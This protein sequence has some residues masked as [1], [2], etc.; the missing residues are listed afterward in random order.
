[1]RWQE[2]VVIPEV[3]EVVTC[4]CCRRPTRSVEGRLTL[5]EEP[6]AR[7]NVRWQPGH[8]EH[9]ARHVLYLGDWTRKGGM[10]DGPAVAAADYQG[11][12]RHGFYL[13]DD[14]AQLLPALK[15][16]RPHY[17]RRADAIGKPL[18]ERLFAM[19]DAIH[20]KDSRLLELR[21]W[22]RAPGEAAG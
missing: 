21:E 1:M 5:H 17:I 10:Q 6:L 2:I 14:A 8:P 4:D 22:G 11:G 19:L 12:D 18:G 7:F 13:R 3:E 16:W 9:S 20:V 15:P